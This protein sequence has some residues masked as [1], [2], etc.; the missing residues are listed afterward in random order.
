[1]RMAWLLDKFRTEARKYAWY[2]DDGT[3]NYN[4]FSRHRRRHQAQDVENM[5]NH[6]DSCVPQQTGSAQLTSNIED[7]QRAVT[8]PMVSGAIRE[9]S[10]SSDREVSSPPVSD[11]S[12]PLVD[13]PSMRK[14]FLALSRRGT[15]NKEMERI[16]TSASAKQRRKFTLWGQ[17]KA[18]LF[19][20]YI[21]ILFIFAPA[22]I[23]VNYLPVS[24]VV[25]FV[26]NFIAIIP[27]AAMLSYATEE[28]S[29]RVGE[30]L[31]G[32]LNATFG[33]VEI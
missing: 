23:L 26:V 9:T 3:V 15:I 14:R 13:K 33:Y 6:S 1:M 2:A 18:T 19:S 8:V 28:L 5:A 17:I 20:S 25:V 31:G 7:I 12:R 22:G 10:L 11:K 27:L 29:L 24:A 30:T 21:N 32:L 16:P 4:P